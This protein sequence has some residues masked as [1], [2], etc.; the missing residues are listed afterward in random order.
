[1]P[2]NHDIGH[3][4]AEQLQAEPS[5]RFAFNRG[6]SHFQGSHA[7][8]NQDPLEEQKKHLDHLGYVHMRLNEVLP[9]NRVQRAIDILQGVE[10]ERIELEK[11]TPRRVPEKLDVNKSIEHIHE[12]L[13]GS[14]RFSKPLSPVPQPFEPTESPHAL[15]N[16]NMELDFSPENSRR[17]M[18]LFINDARKHDSLKLRPDKYDRK[19]HFV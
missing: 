5:R 13:L 9:N 2:R 14:R 15:L 10:Q 1:M 12:R 7:L 4:G 8:P 19:S 17:A 3:Q 11:P 16:K 6:R 18:R